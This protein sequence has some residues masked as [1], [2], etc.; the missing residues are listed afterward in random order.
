MFSTFAPI[1]LFI[2][3]IGFAMLLKKIADMDR[4]QPFRTIL[5]TA[6]LGAIVIYFFLALASEGRPFESEDPALHFTLSEI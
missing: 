1:D 2:L 5:L 3:A 6:I 4:Y